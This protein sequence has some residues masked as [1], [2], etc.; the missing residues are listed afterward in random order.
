MRKLL[1]AFGIVSLLVTGL[2]SAES[3]G[4]LTASTAGGFDNF[5][6]DL[7]IDGD[8]L[9]VGSRHDNDVRLNGGSA[10]VFTRSEGAWTEQA[11]LTAS[12]AGGDDE[13]GRSVD[14]DGDSAI[15]GAWG[16]DSDFTNSGAAYVFVRD[17][18]AWSEQAVLTASDEALSAHFGSA[19]AI[20]GDTAI[21][22][23]HRDPERGS[24][25]GAAYVFT[26]SGGVWQQ[27]AKLHGSDTDSNDQFGIAVALHDGT[28]FVGAS[29]A[30]GSP[31]L[32]AV[33]A[34]TGSADSWTQEAK[35]T[36]SMG[37]GAD[38]FGRD[39]D[40]DGTTLIVGAEGY[41]GGGAAYVFTGSGGA[42]SEEGMLTAADRVSGDSFGASVGI[43]DGV[44][45]V[46]SPFDDGSAP[47]AG[48]ASLF[49]RVDGSWVEA[50]QLAAFD[51]AEGDEF[52]A[53]VAIDEGTLAVGARRAD[54]G[55]VADA[56]AVYVW[57]MNDEACQ[58]DGA[59]SSF[60]HGQVEPAA[61]GADSGVSDQLHDLNCSVVVGLEDQLGL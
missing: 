32:G 52:G 13:F 24:Y 34:F 19:V 30:S 6:A 26:R 9:L 50:D 17:G 56:G 42:W 22:G 46:G 41:A 7:D 47:H 25:S 48:A 59:V 23:A 29:H 61:G 35:I 2:A 44:A 36:P 54:A 28:A 4:K 53:G 49:E 10:F 38:L 3:E 33:Y 55:E 39:L 1:I 18:G 27:R 43:S 58:E 60:V 5:G 45:V 14:L 8:A 51:A 57:F 21:V 37:S 16:H 20:D 11:Q 31:A 40:V 15:I 12:D